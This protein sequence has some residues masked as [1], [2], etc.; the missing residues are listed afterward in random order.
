MRRIIMSDLHIG[1]HFVDHDAIFD[2]IKH[3]AF[4]CDELILNGDILDLDRNYNI[5][6]E[7]M[8]HFLKLLKPYSKIV[9]LAG[10]HDFRIS[11]FIQLPFFPKTN[12][13]VIYGSYRLTHKVDEYKSTSYFIVHGHEFD[14]FFTRAPKIHEKLVQIV[15]WIE[16]KLNFSFERWL[17]KLLLED[18]YFSQQ[19][20]ALYARYCEQADCVV[21]GHTHRPFFSETYVNLGD[22]VE[23]DHHTYLLLEDGKQPQFIYHKQSK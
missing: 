19:E 9:W 12:C 3:E 6:N 5:L 4:H 10:N 22:W 17:N 1:N 21:S 2:F 23:N 8:V 16:A 14:V 20:K 18:F 11:Q 7:Q 13:D 15:G